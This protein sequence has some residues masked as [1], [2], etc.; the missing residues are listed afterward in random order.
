MRETQEALERSFARCA[1]FEGDSLSCEFPLLLCANDEL[2]IF[3]HHPQDGWFERN[4]DLERHGD[5]GGDDRYL[6]RNPSGSGYY[7]PSAAPLTGK[8]QDVPQLEDWKCLEVN[9]RIP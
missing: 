5:R 8:N 7:G 1:F 2:A 4:D 3:H 6:D 9:Q